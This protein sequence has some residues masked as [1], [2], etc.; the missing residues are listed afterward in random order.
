MEEIKRT[1]IKFDE[2]LHRYTDEAGTPYISVTTLIGLYHAKF[3]EDF[4][5]KKKAKESGLPVSVIKQNWKQ[6]RDFA[7]ERGNNEHKL[8][9]DSINDST[10][11]AK[12]DFEKSE[13]KTGLGSI[14]ITK[15]NLNILQDSPLAKKYPKI[16]SFLRKHIEEGWSLYPEKRVYWVDYTIAGTIDCLLV[17]GKLFMIV[18]WKTNKDELKFESGYYKKVNGVK[19]NTWV[20]KKEYFYAPLQNLEY[21][22]GMVYTMQL[23]L[24]A[25]ILELWG[26]KCVGLYLF[27]MRENIAPRDY[28][29]KYLQS[30]AQLLLID[31][32][33]RS[34]NTGKSNFGTSQG[35]LFGIT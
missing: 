1:T 14:I 23:S 7:C 20:P 3:D 25:Y 15:T 16:Y 11:G 9:E 19:T 27:H 28:L 21:C 18:D 26:Y 24:Y 10:G 6:I 8:L 29:I 22:K 13:G 33:M 12:F 2:A 35:N 32:K 5:A 34:A 17:K 31:F 4:W 30:Y